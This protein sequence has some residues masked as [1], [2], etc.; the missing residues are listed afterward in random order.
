MAVATIPPGTHVSL[1]PSD[2]E[3]LRFPPSSADRLLIA[4][5]PAALKAP[6]NR[7][8][9]AALIADDDLC[10]V[11]AVDEVML[12]PNDQ[13]SRDPRPVLRRHLLRGPM[14]WDVIRPGLLA[15]PDAERP[16]Y[17]VYDGDRPWVVIGQSFSGAPIAVPLNDARG[18]S[19][20][21]A[22]TL[23]A[24]ELRFVGSGLRNH[25]TTSHA[26]G[27]V[28]GASPGRVRVSPPTRAGCSQRG[29]LSAD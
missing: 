8:T 23:E 9:L 25:G 15:Q 4:V 18:K 19:K 1:K 6:S 28:R 26:T 5:H 17:T 22:P 11:G 12:V 2:R 13:H 24:Y 16:L 3:K 27:R 29:A 21:W 20:W 10:W 7:L 14:L